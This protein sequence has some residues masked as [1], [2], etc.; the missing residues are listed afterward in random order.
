MGI[1]SESRPQLSRAEALAVCRS[2]S[3]DQ[4]GILSRR[5]LSRLGVPRWVIRL[6]VRSGRWAVRGRQCLSTHNGP[7]DA[8]AMRW[9]AVLE[10]GSRAALDGVSALQA[11]G[12]AGLSD[13]EV[14]VITPKS[15][16]PQHAAGV[17]VRESRMFREDDVV[18]V[19]IRRMRPA[20]A[21]VHA[22]LW[23]VS[24]RQAAYFLT[25]VV[26]QRHA[27]PS[28]LAAALSQV[29][30]HRRRLPLRALIT[31][32]VAG[33]QS[34]GELDVSADLRRRGI[35]VR[36]QTVRKR[37]SGTEYLDIDI[38]GCDVC[39]E[40]DGIG[41]DAPVQRLSDLVR[42]ILTM[43]DGT[44]TVRVPL[45]AYVLDTE[46]VLDA[47]ETLLRSRGWSAAA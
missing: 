31:A 5:Q 16:T 22:A 12:V 34:L 11:A 14:V 36:Q 18:G 8:E 2:V 4:A 1:V 10:V 27:S 37:P 35:P 13:E 44:F 47:L 40:V 23:A 24:D 21:A 20:V 43:A 29:R 41:H 9:I 33:S 46:R 17:V 15:S 45:L 3:G 19:G 32:L 38:E 42:D 39:M 7:L 6:E 26:Q 30:R 25:L 28:D